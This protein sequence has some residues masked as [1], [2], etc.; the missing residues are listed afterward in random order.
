MR[1]AS[2]RA[3]LRLPPFR[4][5]TFDTRYD[6]RFSI[7]DTRRGFSLLSVGCWLLD[8]SCLLLAV[9]RWFEITAEKTRARSPRQP[10]RH[11]GNGRNFGRARSLLAKLSPTD[12]CS[13][14][15]CVLPALPL[16]V[17]LFTSL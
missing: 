15:L 6:T 2:G 12:L 9:G 17:F 5:S 11:C 3:R 1:F 8:V 14:F 13:D 10:K 7:P 4:Y 16:A